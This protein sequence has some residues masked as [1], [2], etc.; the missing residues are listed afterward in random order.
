MIHQRRRTDSEEIDELLVSEPDSQN[1]R[2]LVILSKLSK[3]IDQT[4]ENVQR[5]AG[6]VDALETSVF[7]KIKEHAIKIDQHDDAVLKGTNSWWWVKL[8]SSVLGSA[9]VGISIVAFNQ[10]KDIYTMTNDTKTF[11]ETKIPPDISMSIESQKKLIA[12][13]HDMDDEIMVLKEEVEQIASSIDIIKNKKVFK[14]S[15]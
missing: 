3:N 1:K 10:I 15:K 8:I 14:I 4:S 6:A 11:V 13:I 12:Q 2:I 9:I 5:T 7:E